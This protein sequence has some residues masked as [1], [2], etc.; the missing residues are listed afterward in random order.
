MDL[1]HV[2]RWNRMSKIKRRPTRWHAM[3]LTTDRSW[4]SM[5]CW[6]HRV[7][8]FGHLLEKQE[9]RN[10]YKVAL[11]RLIREVHWGWKTTRQEC[12]SEEGHLTG[13]VRRKENRTHRTPKR[14]WPGRS[15]W[16]DSSCSVYAGSP[17]EWKTK[18]G[19]RF[20]QRWALS[21]TKIQNNKKR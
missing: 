4:H 13:R 11:K 1:L 8:G 2:E 10:K 3:A 21:W 6:G 15:W 9:H 16:S 14:R 12:F 20:G 5:G 17:S 7:D 18:I 19:N